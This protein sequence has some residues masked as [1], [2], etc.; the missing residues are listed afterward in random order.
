MKAPAFWWR[1]RPTLPARLLSPL[2][3]LYGAITQRRMR[4]SGLRIGIPV[5]CV[6]NF[7]AGGAGKTPTAIAIAAL[8][9]QRGETPFVLM[10]GYGG[11]LAG[12]ILVDPERH[13]AADVGD[14]PMLI[15]RHAPT[16]VA[17]DRREGAR[18]AERLG[19]SA[20]VTDDGL[21]NPALV[22][23]ITVAVVDGGGGVGNGLCLPAGPLRAPLPAQL[24]LVEA[25]IVIGSGAAGTQV[26][27]VAALAGKAVLTARLMPEKASSE[28]L[29]GQSVLALSGIGRP[30]KFRATLEGLG[31]KVMAERRFGDHHAYDAADVSGV[32]AQARALGAMVATTEKDMTKLAALW[33]AQAAD[34]LVPVPVTL[35]FD[36]TRAIEALLDGVSGTSRATEPQ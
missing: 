7:I 24:P 8:L 26:A 21:Q 2:G 25:V 11:T 5:I 4:Q 20:I 34:M 15:A 13:G 3:A 30:E 1:D 19:A 31:A 22:K 14:E 12:P 6:G 33:P 29:C 32:I 28:R 18:L 35:V 23:D 27:R 36:D 10:R 17:R 16:I 9:K